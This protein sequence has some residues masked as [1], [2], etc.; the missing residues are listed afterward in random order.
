M[1]DQWAMLNREDYGSE[2][3]PS[4]DELNPIERKKKV[5]SD[6]QVSKM[7]KRM[8]RRKSIPKKESKKKRLK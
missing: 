4:E 5:M 2:S 7:D 1:F 8:R 6:A 3:N